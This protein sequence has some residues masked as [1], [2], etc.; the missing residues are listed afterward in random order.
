M[1]PVCQEQIVAVKKMWRLAVR[2]VSTAIVEPQMTSIFNRFELN[3]LTY[4]KYYD[5]FDFT[6][7]II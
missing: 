1:T 5:F 7:S 4:F 2:Q 6:N 3:Y